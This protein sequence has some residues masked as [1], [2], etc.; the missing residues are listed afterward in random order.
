MYSGPWPR[1]DY[2]F[3]RRRHIC[4]SGAPIAAGY[5]PLPR[6]G[7]V[8]PRGRPPLRR[9]ASNTSNRFRVVQNGSR[10]SDL[11]PGPRARTGA[12]LECSANCLDSFG[13]ADQPEPSAPHRVDVEPHATSRTGLEGKLSA[14]KVIV[15]T[16]RGETA[17]AEALVPKVGA[18]SAAA[19][20][21][22]AR[23]RTS[24]SERQSHRHLNLPRGA[25]F[26]CRQ[27]RPLLE[28]QRSERQVVG[29]HAV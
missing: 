6:H 7:W 10:H 17:C 23:I 22:C 26:T 14:P 9:D 21:T 25:G 24:I 16:V 12:N 4:R 29:R 2:T 11:Q 19:S 8:M 3:V 15:R 27:A 18:Q 13:H 5:G 1:R 28:H 20:T